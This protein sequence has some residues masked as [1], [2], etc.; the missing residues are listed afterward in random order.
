MRA[1]AITCAS[2]LL[3]GLH[4]LAQSPAVPIP[5]ANAPFVGSIPLVASS[6]NALHVAYPVSMNGLRDALIYSRSSDAGRT[7][8]REQLYPPTSNWEKR[9]AL[10]AVGTSIH[11]FVSSDTGVWCRT[12]VDE[13]LTWMPA[14]LVCTGTTRE[15]R[16]VSDGPYLA[17]LVRGVASGTLVFSHSRD[18]GMTWTAT[19]AP[20]PGNS[21][22]AMLRLD[23]NRVHIL[24]WLPN[25]GLSLQSSMDYGLT[26]GQPVP[27]PFVTS[28]PPTV[29]A[30]DFHAEGNSVY[31]VYRDRLAGGI[32]IRR[33]VDY[34]LSF[35]EAPIRLAAGEA[36][37]MVHRSGVTFLATGGYAS[38]I[39]LHRSIDRG[40]TWT[41]LPTPII[42]SEFHLASSNGMLALLAK[43]SDLFGPSIDFHAAITTDFG[44]TWTSPARL[45]VPSG[46]NPV[47]GRDSERTWSFYFQYP[48]FV[49]HDAEMECTS[50][51][52]TC[53]PQLTRFWV[54]TNGG[55][56]WCNRAFA[57]SSSLPTSTADFLPTRDGLAMILTPFGFPANAQ[58]ALHSAL[59]F[60]SQP[61][62]DAKP[63]TGGFAPELFN[64]GEAQFGRRIEPKIDRA[65]GGAPALLAI[66]LSGAARIPLG[67]GEWLLQGPITVVS[68]MTSGPS[69][70]GGVG[71]LAFP[72]VLPIMPRLQGTHINFQALVLDPN[73]ADLF[74]STAGLETWL[75]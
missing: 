46:R 9:H 11:A 48:T 37:D 29:D 33:S 23:S 6:P 26:W 72:F 68:G 59:V 58:P 54:T 52:R 64:A 65:R 3:L 20:L 1:I 62:G 63:G 24:A 34:G 70:V 17:V 25:A 71:S 69:G 56:T 22:Y 32:W 49:F 2:L 36:L 57:P 7:W 8:S 30:W 50:P 21:N 13:G 51:F 61:Y 41:T 67:S 27:A 35:D 15:L 44:A 42:A 53:F 74:S 28:A 39:F 31:F 43:D 18:A 73:A 14:V 10:L 60:G 55:M 5:D 66:S 4:A 19:A 16:I 75:M 38:Q 45:T 12:S 47:T 40:A